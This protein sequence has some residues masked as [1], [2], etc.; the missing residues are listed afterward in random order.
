MS[1]CAQNLF[2]FSSRQV[3]ASSALTSVAYDPR[4]LCLVPLFRG[5][6]VELVE[7]GVLAAEGE[8]RPS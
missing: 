7:A 4:L 8:V 1:S 3:E 6:L 5:E 2:F